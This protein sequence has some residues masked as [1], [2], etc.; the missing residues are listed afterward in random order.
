VGVWLGIALAGLVL[1]VAGGC[2]L[3]ALLVD[4]HIGS[5]ERRL[6]WMATGI[7]LVLLAGLYDDYRPTR[8]RGLVRQV[9]LLAMGRVTSGIVKLVVIVLASAFTA[10]MLGARG[11]RFALAIPVLAASANLWNLLDVVPGRALKWFLPAGAVLLFATDDSAYRL[12][13]GTTLAGSAAAIGLDLREV[14]MLGDSGSNVLGFIVGIGLLS[15]L[16]VVGLAVAL[17]FLLILHVVAETV[18][19]STVIGWTPALRWFDGLGRI[20]SESPGNESHEQDSSVE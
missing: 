20:R 3:S 18:T 2:V 6:L 16:S 8:T 9:R 10:W 4:G 12:V 11:S 5:F 17:A 7:G 19:L 1:A 14:T 15:L 13:A